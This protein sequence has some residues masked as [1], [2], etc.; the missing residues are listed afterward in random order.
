MTDS[1]F[2]VDRPAKWD[3][4]RTERALD[5]QAFAKALAKALAGT[6]QRP[7]TAQHGERYATVLLND[8]KATLGLTAGWKSTELHKITVSIE[9]VGVKHGYPY[10]AEYKTPAATVSTARPMRTIVADIT[11][12]V[13]EP[14]QAPMQKR[15]D[16]HVQQEQSANDLRV[17]AARLT[18]RFPQLRVQFKDGDHTAAIFNNGGH[19]LAARLYPDGSV[20]IDR[21]GSLQSKQF[22]DVAEALFK[23]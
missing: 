14:A 9:P 11:R 20:S 7:D 8:G 10:G 22:A 12:R 2:I 18:A 17:Q 23:P 4:T 21:I 19:Y 1:P 5:V 3:S 16:W 15:R 13:I 6:Y